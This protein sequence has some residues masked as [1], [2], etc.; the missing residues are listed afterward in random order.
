MIGREKSAGDADGVGMV[1]VSCGKD[2]GVEE[3]STHANEKRGDLILRRPVEVVAR[4][5]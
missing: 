3:L 4:R 5:L 1:A 2:A